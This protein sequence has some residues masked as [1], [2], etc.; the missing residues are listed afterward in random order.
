MNMS[1]DRH[2]KTELTETADEAWSDAFVSMHYRESPQTT[3]MQK[4]S[5]CLFSPHLTE[6]AILVLAILRKSLSSV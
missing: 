5:A 6:P 3:I 1:T 4:S 2:V